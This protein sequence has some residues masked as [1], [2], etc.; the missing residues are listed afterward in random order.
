MNQGPVFWI[1]ESINIEAAHQFINAMYTQEADQSRV[2]LV[3]CGPMLPSK[4]NT[5]PSDLKNN[6]ALFPEK[7]ILDRFEKIMVLDNYNNNTYE[8]LWSSLK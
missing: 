8:D 2:N 4:R 3:K 7:S 6:S 1:K 5:L